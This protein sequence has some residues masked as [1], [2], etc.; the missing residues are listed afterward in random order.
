MTTSDHHDDAVMTHEVMASWVGHLRRR[1][2]ELSNH[3]TAIDARLQNLQVQHDERHQ[4]MKDDVR[5]IKRT[6]TDFGVKLD[7]L[8]DAVTKVNVRQVT[9]VG[10]VVWLVSNLDKLEHLTR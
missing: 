2:H 1:T 9:A 10:L 6:M 4:T 3:I 5:E 7:Q 8:R